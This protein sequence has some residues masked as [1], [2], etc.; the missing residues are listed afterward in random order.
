[1]Q[2]FFVNPQLGEGKAPEALLLGTSASGAS[3][4]EGAGCKREPGLIP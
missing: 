4:S 2:H 3:A 1:M